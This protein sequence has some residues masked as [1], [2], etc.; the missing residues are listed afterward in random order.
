MSRKANTRSVLRKEN[1]SSCSSTLRIQIIL[2]PHVMYQFLWNVY[3][4]LSPGV[5]DSIAEGH[6]SEWSTNH[7]IWVHLEP[8]I[9]NLVQDQR[10]TRNDI[11]LATY[12]GLRKPGIFS[13]HQH[14]FQYREAELYLDFQ[15]IRYVIHRNSFHTHCLHIWSSNRDL[16]MHHDEPLVENRYRGSWFVTSLNMGLLDNQ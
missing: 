16:F 13:H 2:K 15:E 6:R 4:I 1:N 5:F 10:Q 9:T 7:P 12:I 8:L 14:N 3:T 11:L